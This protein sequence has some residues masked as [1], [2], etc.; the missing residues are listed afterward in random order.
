MMYRL[1]SV[2]QRL[3][4]ETRLMLSITL[5][6]STRKDWVRIDTQKQNFSE[7]FQQVFQ[8]ESAAL[9]RSGLIIIHEVLYAA[10][11]T[12]EYQTYMYYYL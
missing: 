10:H 6:Y 4:R 8:H 11:N 1:P 7:K 9:F 5:L 12:Q 2:T 3:P